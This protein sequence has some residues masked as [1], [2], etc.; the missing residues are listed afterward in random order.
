MRAGATLKGSADPMGFECFGVAL[1]LRTQVCV[2]EARQVPSL[3]QVAGCAQLNELGHVR[4]E[5]AEGVPL[6]QDTREFTALRRTTASFPPSVNSSASTRSPGASVS[7]SVSFSSVRRRS[8][9]PQSRHGLRCRPCAN[10]GEQ[11]RTRHR[12]ASTDLE[13]VRL[14]LHPCRRW[15]AAGAGRSLLGHQR[16]LM[17]S[18]DVV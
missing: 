5:N 7:V 18:H 3:P 14:P 12:A 9:Q 11:L 2:E 10:A 8:E 15:C 6:D 4:L 13:N 16:S 17:A 1:E